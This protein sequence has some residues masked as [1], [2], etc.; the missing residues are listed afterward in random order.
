MSNKQNNSKWQKL[1]KE[2]YGSKTCVQSEWG[3]IDKLY[4]GT[5]S[6]ECMVNDDQWKIEDVLVR[7]GHRALIAKFNE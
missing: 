7:L 2:F 1:K 3:I 4:R 6:M 5:L